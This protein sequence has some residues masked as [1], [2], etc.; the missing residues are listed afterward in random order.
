MENNTLIIETL[1]A[2]GFEPEQEEERKVL[3]RFEYEK[4]DLLYVDVEEDRSILHIAMPNIY[5]ITDY[6]RTAVYEAICNTYFPFTKLKIVGNYVWVIYEHYLAT[7]ENIEQVLKHIISHIPATALA[8]F[9]NIENFDIEN[10]I[11]ELIEDTNYE[12]Y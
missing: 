8:F 3:W 11:D 12:M 10:K 7:D 1:R 6:N 2:L 4:F 5:E 9:K